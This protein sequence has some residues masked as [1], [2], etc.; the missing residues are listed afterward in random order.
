MFKLEK[1]IMMEMEIMRA[2][3]AAREA[4]PRAEYLAPDTT[5]ERIFTNNAV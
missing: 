4:A 2:V 1:D 5:N 3:P